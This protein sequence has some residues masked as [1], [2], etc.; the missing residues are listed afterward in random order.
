VNALLWR[1][2]NT[3][4]AAV[5][6]S[7]TGFG[8][9]LVL[10]LTAVSGRRRLPLVLARRIWAPGILRFACARLEVEGGE[11]IDPTRPLF[12]VANHGSILDI[13]A[14]FAALPSDLHFMVKQELRRQPFLG[15]F[16][17]A[18]GMILV[19][20]S[21]RVGA[22]AS[23][24]RATELIRSGGSVMAFPEGTRSRSGAIGEF[25]SGT[26]I[27][28]IESQVPVV[29]VGIRGAAAVVPPDRFYGRP[30]TIRVVVGGAI[31][32]ARLTLD[33]RR[34]LAEEARARVVELSAAPNSV[35]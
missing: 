2:A 1:I 16:I 25:K 18:T 21:K 34:R 15:W 31:P 32:T 12:F 4:Q 10:P 20:R 22:L 3:I 30:G 8:I 14:V 24:R 28:A 5:M 17:A 11:W 13:P 23:A 29:P 33:D 35:P 9:S 26:F 7:W 19:D 6:L 27:P